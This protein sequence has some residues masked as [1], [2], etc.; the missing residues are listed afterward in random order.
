MITAIETCV[1]VLSDDGNIDVEH[2]D[3]AI[4]DKHLVFDVSG[5]E[6]FDLAHCYQEAIQNSDTDSAIYWLAKW[7]CSGED[8]AY[9]SR[10][11]LVTAFEDCATSPSAWLSAMAACFA[12]ERI[13]MPECMIPM[14]LATCEM[15]LSTRSKYA[16]N[17]IKE[18]MCDVQNNTTVHVPPELRAGTRGYV[19]AITKQY[20]KST[21]DTKRTEYLDFRGDDL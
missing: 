6:H 9:I 3:V 5:N 15:G 8:P 12:V 21:I 10:R 11:M 20:V 13:G 17:A 16:Y 14:S 7:L 2:I 19:K 1:E 18:A 4:P